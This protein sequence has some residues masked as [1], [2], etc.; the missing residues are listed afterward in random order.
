[1]SL[2]GME[3]LLEAVK[4][5]NEEITRLHA[6]IDAANAGRGFA[7]SEALKTLQ[8]WY[9]REKSENDRLRAEVKRRGELLRMALEACYVAL[10][11]GEIHFRTCVLSAQANEQLTAVVKE[12]EAL[13]DED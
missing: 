10:A 8:E 4:S 13:T 3:Q 5:R 12:I 11:T 2:K 7:Q 9:E 1:M 6:I